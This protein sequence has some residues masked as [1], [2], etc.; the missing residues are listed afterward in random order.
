MHAFPAR[1]LPNQLF[2]QA[3]SRR[4]QKRSLLSKGEE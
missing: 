2:Y 3:C 4:G 1:R